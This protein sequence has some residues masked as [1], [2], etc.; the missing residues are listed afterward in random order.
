MQKTY[1]DISDLLAAKARRRRELASLSWEE[2]VEI[3]R[4]MQLNM[5]KDAWSEADAV[6]SNSHVEGN[7]QRE[8]S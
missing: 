7:Q 2:K 3:V 1:P 6:E 5:L 4:R 8:K